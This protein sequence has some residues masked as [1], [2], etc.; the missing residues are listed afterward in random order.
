MIDLSTDFR[1][2]SSKIY[3]KYYSI[4]H[5][6]V[7]NINKSIYALPEIKKD[8]RLQN[9]WLPWLLSNIYSAS[10]NSSSEKNLINKKAM[11]IIDSKSGYSGAGRNVHRNSKIKIYMNL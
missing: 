7:K 11:I 5:S 3:S 10:F 1:L 9:S 8:K 2:K 4:K 6:A